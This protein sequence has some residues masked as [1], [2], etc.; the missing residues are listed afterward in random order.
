MAD[1]V[2]ESAERQWPPT[3]PS[4][5]MFVLVAAADDV[6]THGCHG[7][8]SGHRGAN[9]LARDIAR[10]LGGAAA[11]TTAGDVALGVA[12]DE[13]PAGWR[14]AGSRPLPLHEK[15]GVGVGVSEATRR[16]SA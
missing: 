13:P 15:I 16:L 9:R 7:L 3:P 1:V 10:A 5:P 12:L 4:S 6:L 14:L 2:A 11:V 8:A